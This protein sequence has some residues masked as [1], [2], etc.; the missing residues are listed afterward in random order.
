MKRRKIYTVLDIWLLIFLIDVVCS[1]LFSHPI[2]TVKISDADV[3]RYYG[4]GYLIDGRGSGFSI[5]PMI[6]L[7]VNAVIRLKLF[8]SESRADKS[9]PS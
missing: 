1:F 9:K 3:T 5:N 2:F 4:L 6:Y 8:M 7:M